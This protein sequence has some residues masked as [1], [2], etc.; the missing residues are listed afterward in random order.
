MHAEVHGARL[1]KAR[2]QRLRRMLREPVELGE[3][4]T[5]QALCLV[6]AIPLVM[7]VVMDSI[8]LVSHAEAFWR[9]KGELS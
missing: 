5:I 9:R 7:P 2:L 8:L 3:D 4:G 6:G 1:S